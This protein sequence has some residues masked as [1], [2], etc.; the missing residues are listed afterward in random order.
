MF[1]FTGKV[2]V[3]SGAN[4]GITRAVARA[5]HGCGARMV[6][7]DLDA[8]AMAAFAAEL[9]P[10]GEIVVATGC[11][12][13][14]SA[15]VE[16]AVA[17]C[18]QRFGGADFLVTGAGLYL[19]Q[20]SAGMTDAQWRQAIAVNLD[21]TF[22]FCR[23]IQR[24]IRDGGAIVNI[25]SVAAHRGSRLHAHYAAAKG[26]VLGLTRSLAIELAPRNVRVN[27]VSPGVIETAMTASLIEAQGDTLI[28]LTP[29][30]RFGRPEEV[31]SVIL[32]LCS[33]L[34]SF[35]TGETIHING[36]LYIT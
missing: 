10:A 22:H 12:V 6:L 13:A 2:M 21:G 26:G 27:A 4:G 35:V 8:D 5:F 23:A 33:E 3:L 25:A 34:A 18:E 17:L 14:D 28:G 31:A 29:L 32:F 11:D 36:G 24:I 9:D 15:A 7:S 30:K 1:D 16:A 19:D 20:L